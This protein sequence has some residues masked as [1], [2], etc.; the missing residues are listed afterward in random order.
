M[1]AS[2]EVSFK[3]GNINKS[4]GELKVDLTLRPGE[5][6]DPSLPLAMNKESWAIP[7]FT[8]RVVVVCVWSLK[9]T[10][11]SY[12]QMWGL[13]GSLMV[14]RVLQ[15]K[16][17]SARSCPHFARGDVERGRQKES[18]LSQVSKLVSLCPQRHCI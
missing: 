12:S 15:R 3:R 5:C 18:D 6:R 17:L 9:Q 13:S 16:P 2:A 7:E 11:L 8:A 10:R 14:P 1:P 4:I